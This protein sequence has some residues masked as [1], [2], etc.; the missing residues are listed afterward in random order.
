[1]VMVKL[2]Q[3]LVTEREMFATKLPI[4]VLVVLRYSRLCNKSVIGV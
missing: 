1:M 2:V 4:Q 3:K